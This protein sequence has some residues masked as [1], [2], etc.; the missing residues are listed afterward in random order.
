MIELLTPEMANQYL[1]V[2]KPE[3]LQQMFAAA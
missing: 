1:Q 2:T 3:N